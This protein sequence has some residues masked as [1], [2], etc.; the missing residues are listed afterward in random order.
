MKPFVFT[1]YGKSGK[2][3]ALTFECESFD[4]LDAML[5]DCDILCRDE[6]KGEMCEYE[7][8]N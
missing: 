5:E 7:R 4:D 3:Y 6:D 1:A 8:N 2:S